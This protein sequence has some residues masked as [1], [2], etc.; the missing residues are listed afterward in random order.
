MVRRLVGEAVE[1]RVDLAPGLP[2]VRADRAQLGA[3]LLNLA[4]NARDAMPDGGVLRISTA[5]EGLEA[6]RAGRLGLPPGPCVVIEV[7]DSGVGIDEATRARL[8]EPF[9]T[10]KAAGHGL[11]LASAH[12]TVRQLGGAVEVESTAGQGATFRVLLPPAKESPAALQA[13]PAA[14]APRGTETVLL[15][16]DEPAVLRYVSAVL[17]GLGYQ[18]LTAG[19]GEE[20]LALASGRTGKVDVLVSDLLMPRM[21]GPELRARLCADRPGL[22]T[23]FITGYAGDALGPGHGAA[24][25]AVVLAK[26]FTPGELGVAVRRALDARQLPSAASRSCADSHSA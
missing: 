23:V 24:D 5:A 18:V 16:E 21:G 10:T 20:A 14:D 12:G 6:D 1:V 26:P 4:A 22:P 3:A 15:A 7:A 17:A 25:G 11:G 2:A 9:F 13:H 19:G 8:V